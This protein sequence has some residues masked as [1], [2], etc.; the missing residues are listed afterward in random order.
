MAELTPRDQEI[1]EAFFEHLEN[2]GGYPSAANMAQVRELSAAGKE[3][4]ARRMDER[5]GIVMPTRH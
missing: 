5:V 1:L 2:S 3:E 4:F